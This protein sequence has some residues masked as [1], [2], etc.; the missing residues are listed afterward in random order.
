MVATVDPAA[1][2]GTTAPPT[3]AIT[4]AVVVLTVAPI[5]AA[6]RSSNATSSREC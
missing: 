6:P 1:S 4:T 5:G 3:E 2:A